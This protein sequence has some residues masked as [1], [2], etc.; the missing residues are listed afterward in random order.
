M[1]SSGPQIKVLIWRRIFRLNKH[2]HL[3][4]AS[5]TT[6][7]S[8]RK[9]HIFPTSLYSTILSSF[10]HSRYDQAKSEDYS[11]HVGGASSARAREC[12]EKKGMSL[13]KIL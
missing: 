12:R 2:L 9:S 7:S 1:G 3:L 11:R 8:F 13:N 5:Y 10:T 4:S 6:S